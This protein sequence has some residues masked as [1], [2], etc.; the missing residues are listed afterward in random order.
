MREVKQPAPQLKSLPERG[1]SAQDET[2]HEASAVQ[3]MADESPQSAPLQALREMAAASP[4]LAVQRARRDAMLGSERMV[5]QRELVAG[6]QPAVTQRAAPA[7]GPNGLPDGLRAGIEEISGMA[8]DG[9]QVHYNSPKPAQL[10]AHAYAQGN[11]IHLGPG[12]E[13]HLPHEAWHV[14]QQRQGRVTAN[15]QHK[16]ITINDDASLERE[17]DVMGAQALQRRTMTA[18]VMGQSAVTGT[19][20]LQRKIKIADTPE[21]GGWAGLI[22]S[23]PAASG[24]TVPVA[25]AVKW[26]LRDSRTH[27]FPT[28]DQLNTDVTAIVD[29]GAAAATW[30]AQRFGITLRGAPRFTGVAGTRYMVQTPQMRGDMHDVRAAMAVDPTMRLVFCMTGG[31]RIPDAGEI[32]SFYSGLEARIDLV[33][34]EPWDVKPAPGVAIGMS[35]ATI[36]LLDAAERDPQAARK[37]IKTAITGAPN[38]VEEAAYR[39]EL[40]D[41]GF[42]SGTPYCIINYRDSGHKP[43]P[44]R[45]PSH[46]ELDTGVAGMQQLCKI[47]LS[48]GFTPVVM[49]SPPGGDW[50]EPNL[51]NYFTWPCCKP[52]DSPSAVST[53]NKRQAE[54]GL[55]RYMAEHLNVRAV[56]MRSG[57]TDAMVFSGMETISLDVAYIE[58]ASW[59][60][61]SLRDQIMPG[62]FHQGFFEPRD[63][64]EEGQ[65]VDAWVGGFDGDNLRIIDKLF[66]QFFGTAKEQIR[67]S[68]ELDPRHPFRDPRLSERIITQHQ[69]K[70]TD[71]V[72]AQKPHE[73]Q[74]KNRKHQPKKSEVLK[75]LEQRVKYTG[76][77]LHFF[78]E[79]YARWRKTHDTN[80]DRVPLLNLA[81]DFVHLGHALDDLV[82]DLH[83]LQ[84]RLARL[85]ASVEELGRSLD[86]MQRRLDAL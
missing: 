6:H 40:Q 22:S 58:D 85:K 51:L 42:K 84:V 1:L 7:G 53:R 30:L 59:Q 27:P 73:E 86:D 11:D 45:A 48:R 81:E 68:T 38:E 77:S 49:G 3:R 60:R 52:I 41:R 55:L 18:P 83:D 50:G 5:A 39:K 26:M 9:V 44:G 76:A 31:D 82:A 29:T 43:E 75:K 16:G 17:A 36:T 66:D 65:H 25:S 78:G 79:N 37:A 34:A 19:A 54:Y 62:V 72:E 8:M 28:F 15:M 32:L 21:I 63:D 4:R 13:Q 33:A 71:A 47:A 80:E 57:V 24:W 23:H 20:P 70:L 12:Q 69:Q 61:A 35:D 46:P 10:Q 67:H 2:A 56:S 74:P 64:P 14:V